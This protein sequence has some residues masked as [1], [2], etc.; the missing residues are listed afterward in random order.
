[1]LVTDR[2]RCKQ[3]T[4]ESQIRR[5]VQGGL[6]LIQ[7]RERELSAVERAATFARL[8]VAAPEAQWLINDDS[9]LARAQH[10]GLHRPASRPAVGEESVPRPYGRSVHDERELALA[11]DDGV[12]YLV[13]GTIYPTDSKPG[14]EGRGVEWI[15]RVHELAGSRP[16][17]AIGG[18]TLGR[19]PELQSAGAHGVAV[20][21]ALLNA[22][23]P[24]VEARRLIDALGDAPL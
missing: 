19:I 3:G 8:A 18:V 14:G 13:V 5:A 21:N 7:F 12:D 11:L 1:M 23:D 9:V 17:Y 10:C 20:C 2:Q 4:L 24:A 6:R 16:I 15:A 22:V